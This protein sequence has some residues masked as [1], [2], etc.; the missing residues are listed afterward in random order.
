MSAQLDELIAQFEN[1]QAKVRQAEAS[2]AGVGDMQERISQVENAVT[3][4]DGAVTVVAG[5]GGTVTDIRL[6][7]GATRLDSAQLSALIMNTL[8]QAVAGAVQQQAGI[9]DDAFGDAF[10][11]NTSEQVRQAQAEAWGTEAEEPASEQPAPQQTAQRATP[12]R[13]PGPRDDD[14]Y[15]EDNSILRRD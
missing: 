4:P 10:G 6:A 12:R 7:A 13:R 9:V 8:R 3:S 11:V 5:A 1:F 15:F 14:D 2:F